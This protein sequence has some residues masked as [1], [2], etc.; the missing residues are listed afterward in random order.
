[1]KCRIVGHLLFIY[2]TGIV[3]PFLLCLRDDIHSLEKFKF[4]YLRIP[5]R[6]FWG[7]QIIIKSYLIDPNAK[8]LLFDTLT[9][10]LLGISDV[11][12]TDNTF[13]FLFYVISFILE[14]LILQL[15]IYI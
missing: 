13:I 11:H 15:L 1:M 3:S 4:V 2:L 6:F 5:N 8:I 12:Q 10:V 9:W 14:F 7:N